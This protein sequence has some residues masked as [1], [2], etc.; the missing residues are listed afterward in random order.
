MAV[1]TIPSRN[2]QVGENTI[3]IPQNKLDFD[4]YKIILTREPGG[5][6]PAGVDCALDD[7]TV[8]SNVVVQIIFQSSI[9]SGN[10]WTGAGS[11]TFQGGTIINHGILL[12]ESSIEFS[13]RDALTGAIKKQSGMLRVTARVLVPLRTAV[14]VIAVESA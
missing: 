8:Q 12:T 14:T 2:Y 9:D 10:T 7:G 1:A 3:T 11:A 5:N 6:W 13:A 4:S